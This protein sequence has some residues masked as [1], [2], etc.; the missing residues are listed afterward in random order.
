[1]F[2]QQVLSKDT[3]F[4]D[5]ALRTSW[6]ILD[7]Q[8]QTPP[9]GSSSLSNWW[10]Q[11]Y[12]LPERCGYLPPWVLPPSD[13]KPP[14]PLLSWAWLVACCSGSSASWWWAV[15]EIQFGQG[16][17]CSHPSPST[18]SVPGLHRPALHRVALLC[19][20]V[21]AYFLTFSGTVG[22]GKLLIPN[23][24]TGLTATSH[25]DTRARFTA[26]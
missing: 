20:Y 21:E 16:I 23:E 13:S 22:N 8:L 1:M 17:L 26:I 14:S 6:T 25:F 5:N 12:A 10:S 9:T 19:S 4:P 7:P 24:I 2:V 18:R 11:H 3:T 15:C